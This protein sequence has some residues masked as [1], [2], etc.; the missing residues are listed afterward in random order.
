[1]PPAIVQHRQKDQGTRAEA[2]LEP[3]PHE[4]AGLS[5]VLAAVQSAGNAQLPK[6]DLHHAAPWETSK[7]L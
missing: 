5:T 4:Q 1:M 7:R 2:S 6:V 3:K